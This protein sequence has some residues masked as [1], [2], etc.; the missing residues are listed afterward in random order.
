MYKWE[1]KELKFRIKRRRTVQ[2]LPWACS[3]WII[4]GKLLVAWK[5]K[6]ACKNTTWKIIK[7]CTFGILSSV[8]VSLHTVQMKN[9]DSFVVWWDVSDNCSVKAKAHNVSVQL[10]SWLTNKHPP[11]TQHNN[12]EMKNWFGLSPLFHGPRSAGSPL[13]RTISRASY[14]PINVKLLGRGRPGIGEG[15]ELRSKKCKF[16]TPGLLLLVKK[17]Q[18]MIKSPCHGQTRNVKSPSYARPPLA[19][20]IGALYYAKK[21]RM[22]TEPVPE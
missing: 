12:S 14:A 16:L 1:K 13:M 18:R 17:T 20:A 11:S 22:F 4:A 8:V 15:F 19:A 21:K 10:N 2:N 7:H 3:S 6:M 9:I 5:I